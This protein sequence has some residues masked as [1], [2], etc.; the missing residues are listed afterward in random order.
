MAAAGPNPGQQDKEIKDYISTLKNST[1]HNPVKRLKASLRKDPASD[2]YYIHDD[3]LCGNF[4]DQGNDII[5]IDTLRLYENEKDCMIP[6][7]ELMKTIDDYVQKIG[8]ERNKEEITIEL[9]DASTHQINTKTGPVYF[10]TMILKL[11][12]GFQNVPSFYE[13]YGFNSIYE[14]LGFIEI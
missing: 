2:I 4:I 14:S 3:R 12:S 9:E 6:F 11:Y 10:S 8:S 1:K 13:K 5:S 7:D